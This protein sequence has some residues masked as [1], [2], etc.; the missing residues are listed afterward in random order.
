V[1][2]DAARALA[3]SFPGASEEPHFHYSSFRVNGK[4]FA[5]M[6]PSNELLHVFVPEMDREAAVAAYPGTCQALHW[7][8]R[9]VGVKIDLGKARDDL[10]ADLLSAAWESKSAGR[11]R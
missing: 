2:S 9:V 5:T 7:G 11:K 4:I 8:K 3:L 1:N 10:V 6:P